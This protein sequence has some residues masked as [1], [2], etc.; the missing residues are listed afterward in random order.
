MSI[1]TDTVVA[2]DS[3]ER[4]SPRHILKRNGPH[5]AACG[6]RLQ[7]WGRYRYMEGFETEKDQPE[8]DCRPCLFA[9]AV[10]IVTDMFESIPL[11]TAQAVNAT[12]DVDTKIVALL[13]AI[14]VGS[15]WSRSTLIQEHFPRA[16][17]ERATT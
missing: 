17:V 6:E 7:P 1:H 14:L 10:Q 15:A 11:E 9:R 4:L 16:L 3:T 8:A 12:D 13:R 2:F 5:V